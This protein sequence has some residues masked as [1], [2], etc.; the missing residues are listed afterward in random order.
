VND[1]RQ[2]LAR[3]LTSLAAALLPVA[4]MA[5]GPL[6]ISDDGTPFVW[7]TTAAIPYRIDGGNLSALVDGAAAQTRVANMFAVWRNVGSS[8][9]DYVR[10]GSIQSVPGFTDGDVSNLGEFDAIEGDC[11]E[12][13][14]N[15]IIYDADGTIFTALGIDVTTVI[16]FTKHCAFD[17]LAGLII[18]GEVVMNGL[19]LDGVDDDGN[20]V[21]LDDKLGEFDAI[22]VH[23][24]GHFS[25]LDHSQINVEC[26]FVNCGADNIAGLPTMFPFFVTGTQGV[27]SIDDIAWISKLYPA[28]GASGF[29]ATHG[30]IS[31]TVFFSDGE[32]HAQGV[33][34]VARRVDNPATVGVNE[35]LTAAGSNVSGYKFRYFNGNPINADSEPFGSQLPSHIGLYEI[36]LPPGSYTVE[37]ESIDPQFEEGSSV[38]GPI[39]ID[40]PGLAPA[41]IGPINVTAGAT[42][43]S[44]DVT[45]IGTDPRFDQFEGP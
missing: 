39:R 26:G 27:L 4:A 21:D 14:Q 25:G 32:S 20:P 36:P 33:N 43:S 12:G 22:F 6:N 2:L 10:A 45:L 40:M 3:I 16:G 31:G 24:F 19:F 30:T 8:S 15:P 38:G 41:P 7:D 9:I 44:R 18:S 5:G 28:A 23:E 17:P 29:T 35:S 13:D 42:S 34:V 1:V 37:F 11:R